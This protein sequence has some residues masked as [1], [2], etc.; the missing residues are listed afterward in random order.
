MPRA[1]N[2]NYTLPVGNPVV[3]NTPISSTVQNT[4]MSD[5]ASALSDSL[6]RS[7]LG[8]M[9]AP[10]PFAAGTVNSPGFTWSTESVSGF[11]LAGTNDMRATVAGVQRMRW[12]SVGVDVWDTLNST[13]LP[14]STAAGSNFAALNAINSFTQAQRIVGATGAWNVYDA[15][16]PTFATRL[17]Q[18]L[19]GAGQLGVDLYN[20]TSWFPIVLASVSQTRFRG[21]TI[22]FD[23]D[24]GTQYGAVDTTGFLAKAGR[25]FYAYEVANVKNVRMAHDGANGYIITPVGSGGLALY[26]ENVARAIFSDTGM[27]LTAGLSLFLGSNT[28][29]TNAASGRYGPIVR[30]ADGVRGS[31]L[32][33][34]AAANTSGKVIQQTTTPGA[35]GG[36]PFSIVLVYE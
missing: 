6:S 29:F 23:S 3:T 26:T 24:G 5:V 8:G 4:T 10:L 20:G 27:A 1:A 36:E 35:T 18:G 12:T 13:W 22:A 14:L 9:L 7:G 30:D 2:G 34:S 32:Y 25:G 33:W 11:Y 31:A 15:A 19:W 17:S 21:V 16:V 28:A